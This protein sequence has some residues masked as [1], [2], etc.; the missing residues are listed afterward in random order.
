MR[1]SCKP[2][3]AFLTFLVALAVAGREGPEMMSLA[4]DTSN[5]GDVIVQ[6]IE[7]DACLNAARVPCQRLNSE[8]FGGL[9]AWDMSSAYLHS[10]EISP[11]EGHGAHS[12]SDLGVRRI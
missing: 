9:I 10:E 3:L 7:V 4:D 8:V 12:L 1:K 11:F 6:A 5:D 2:G